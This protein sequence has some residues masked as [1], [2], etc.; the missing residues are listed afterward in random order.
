[1]PQVQICVCVKWGRWQEEQHVDVLECE[2]HTTILELKQR[3]AEMAAA[4]AKEKGRP[5][6]PPEPKPEKQEMHFM[7][8]ICDNTKQLHDYGICHD[9][10]KQVGG[11]VLKPKFPA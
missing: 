1:M 3:A 8:Q 11:F 10:I 4:A 5:P 6:A 2:M 7:G 9:W